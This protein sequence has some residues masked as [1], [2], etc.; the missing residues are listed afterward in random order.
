MWEG[1]ISTGFGYYPGKGSDVLGVGL[2]WSRP[3]TDTFGPGLD[4]QLTAELYY[5]WQVLKILA[6]T[7]DVQLLINPALNPNEDV[8]GVFSIRGRISL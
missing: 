1:S 5:R 6:I 4:D 7:P 8:I 2:N 3:S